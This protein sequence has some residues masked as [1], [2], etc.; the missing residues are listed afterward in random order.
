VYGLALL[1]VA[2][3]IWR[4]T[5]DFKMTATIIGGGLAALFI[6]GLLIYALLI[7][8]RRLLPHISLSWRFGL[9]G[10]L[11]T[12]KASVSQILAFSIT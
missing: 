10:L 2:T 6:C 7:Q 12:P 5:Q 1:L 3:L 9:Q 8:G 4:Y 11:K